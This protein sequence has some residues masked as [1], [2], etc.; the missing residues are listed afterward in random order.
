[1]SLLTV[2]S[3]K[4]EKGLFDLLE[5]GFYWTNAR[6]FGNS[7][8]WVFNSPSKRKIMKPFGYTNWAE[9]EPVS[10]LYVKQISSYNMK[11]DYNILFWQ[12]G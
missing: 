5:D 12:L 8:F 4:D 2:E 10:K 7:W 6:R 11:D 1:M 9:N 3:K